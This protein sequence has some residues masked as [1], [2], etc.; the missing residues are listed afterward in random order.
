MNSRTWNRRI[1]LAAASVT[2]VGGVALPATAM[3]AP[4]TPQHTIT[5]TPHNDGNDHGL[6]TSD[7]SVP[8]VMGGDLMDPGYQQGVEDDDQ[9]TPNSN[10]G[11]SRRTPHITEP[12]GNAVS[13]DDEEDMDDYVARKSRKP[14]NHYNVDIYDDMDDYV[15]FKN[16]V[17][18]HV[19]D[20]D[21]ELPPNGN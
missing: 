4:A 17:P 3:A 18:A 11:H 1:V 5:Q 15:Y 8:G 10:G 19:N 13:G 7:H 14:T 16:R 21:G 9:D 6:Q 20:P 2:L 12:G